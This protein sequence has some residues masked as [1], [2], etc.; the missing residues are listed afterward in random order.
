[1]TATSA[2][3]SLASATSQLLSTSSSSSSSATSSSNSLTGTSAS[4]EQDRFLKLLV[5]QL[6]NQDPM[7]PMDN[8]EMTSQ[9]AQINTVTGISQLNDTM[10]S[11]NTQMSTMQM[12]QASN[13]VG[14]DVLTTGN[15]LAYSSDGKT[16]VG[17]VDLAGAA[18]NVQ[19]QVT[20]AGGQ[21]VD[22]VQLGAL[23]AGQHEFSL[24]SSN[25][26]TTSSLTF[27]VTA[28]NSGTAVNSTA[29]M[30]DQVEAVGTDSSGGLTLN[31]LN[32]GVTP[33][34]NVH[35]VL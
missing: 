9:I 33:Y 34:S 20:T 12:L 4:D 25:Y 7:N 15:S 17:A 6:A 23:S 28:T 1:M 27:K 10:K 14:Q 13:L 22:T 19:V 18:T 5:A 32:S 16:A 35:S 21:V 29:L 24:D 8:S 3:D 26:P 31:L 11:M 30:R 2:T